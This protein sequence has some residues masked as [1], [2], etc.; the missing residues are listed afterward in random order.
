MREPAPD[1]RFQSQI[2]NHHFAMPP[3]LSALPE[4]QARLV[5]A[6]RLTVLFGKAGKCPIA[7][8]MPWVGGLASATH[9]VRVVQ[10]LGT[11]W[12]EP[13]RIYRP[14]CPQSS[15]DEML[16]LDM[17]N[18]MVLRDLAGFRALLSDMVCEAAIGAIQTE[19]AEFTARHIRPRHGV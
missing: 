3:A 18:A 2:L 17:I 9:F 15:T 10:I 8:I 12:P 7:Q 1:T 13:I 6:F 14:C 16:L 5:R 4:P 19:L 11:Y